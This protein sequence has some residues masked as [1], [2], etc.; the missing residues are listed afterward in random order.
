VSR[1]DAVLF[2]CDGV[3]ADTEPL[4]DRVIAEEVTALGWPMGPEE[5]RRVF[6]GLSWQAMEPVIAGRIG[7]PVPPDWHG[8]LIARVVRALREEVPPVPGAIEA[9]AALRRAGVA[10]ACA[11]NS[12]AEELSLKLE[13]LGLAA[14]F[15]GRAFSR[16]SV[17]R[18]KPAPDMYLA[19]AA[20]CRAVPDRCVVIEDSVVGA[21]AGLAAGCRVLGYDVTAGAGPLAAEGVETFHRMADLPGLLGVCG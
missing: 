9:V 5:A 8:A 2:D 20:A 15:A 19:A 1:P 18:P 13:R 21:R 4:H 11:S 17:A 12:S 10:V 14:A 3:L 16:D 7:R 6:L